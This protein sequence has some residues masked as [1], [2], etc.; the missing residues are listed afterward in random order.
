[1]NEHQPITTRAIHTNMLCMIKKWTNDRKT[2]LG[3]RHL[4]WEIQQM[5]FLCK[6]TWW[7]YFLTVGS[8]LILKMEMRCFPITTSCGKARPGSNC[9]CGVD[10]QQ[11]NIKMKSGRDKIGSCR[12][13]SKSKLNTQLNSQKKR[14]DPWLLMKQRCRGPSY[15]NMQQQHRWPPHTK[16]NKF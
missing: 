5:V 2:W 13:S 6:S 7:E 8:M 9:Q 1:M 14:Q 4:S 3:N 10:R 16:P 12:I 15:L 11:R